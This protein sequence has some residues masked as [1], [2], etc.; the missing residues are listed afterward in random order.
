MTRM[1]EAVVDRLAGQTP[2]LWGDIDTWHR[3][4][5]TGKS[6]EEQRAAYKV[7]YQ[8][9]RKTIRK[10]LAAQVRAILAAA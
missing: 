9:A 3:A 5:F 2:C 6:E 8:I 4:C 10:R 7:A 1:T